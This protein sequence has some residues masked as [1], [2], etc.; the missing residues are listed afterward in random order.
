ME[1]KTGHPRL[2]EVKFTLYRIFRNPSAVIGVVLLGAFTLVALLAPYIAPPKYA[3]RP[4]MMPHKGYSMEPKAPDSENIFGTT[5]GQY[6]IFYGVVWGTRT[7]FRIGIIVVV[8][9]FV[10]GASLGIAAGYYG[11][12]IDEIIM[13]V[14]DVFFAV[15]FTILA[16]AFVVRFGRGLDQIMIALVL[17]VWRRYAR[18]MRAGV[19]SVRNEDYILA[20]KSMGVSDVKIMLRHIFPNAVYPVMV[21]A[22]MDAGSIVITAAFLSFIGLG[23]PIGYADW[24]QMLAMARNYI[25]GPAGEP[26]KYWYTV[27][28][29]GCAMILFVLA[30]NLFGDAIRDAFDPKLRRK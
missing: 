4:Y 16:M 14:V 9:A 23:A 17:V 19:L 6:D 12:W 1:T 27:F 24:G 21:I 25:V 13:R 28:F 10:I 5:S 29:P 20:A 26:L 11:G 3:H 7:A 18:V 8:T 2:K 30:W 22:F 15:P